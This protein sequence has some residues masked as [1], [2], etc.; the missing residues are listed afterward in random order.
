MSCRALSGAL[1]LVAVVTGVQSGLTLAQAYPSKP[2][3]IIVP[4]APGGPDDILQLIALAMARTHGL[5]RIP[6]PDQ[7]RPPEEPF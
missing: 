5:T 4:F 3:R 7:K 1:V 6:L 2:I